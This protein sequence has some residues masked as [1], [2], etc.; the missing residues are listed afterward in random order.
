MSNHFILALW[1]VIALCS[2]PV[3]LICSV[4]KAVGR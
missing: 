1:Q 3:F 4:E 2:V